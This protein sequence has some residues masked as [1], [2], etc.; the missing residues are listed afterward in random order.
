MGLSKLEAFMQM[1][2]KGSDQ[3]ELWCGD[4]DRYLSVCGR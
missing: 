1:S 2:W 3:A 4:F